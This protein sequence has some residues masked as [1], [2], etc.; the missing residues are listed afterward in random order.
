LPHTRLQL[1]LNADCI[2]SS[3]TLDKNIVSSLASSFSDED[4][5]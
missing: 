2:R 3:P 5:L 4:H 1:S